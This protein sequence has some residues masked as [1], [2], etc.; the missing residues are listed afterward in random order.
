M[1][2]MGAILF[3][4]GFFLHGCHTLVCSTG[5]THLFGRRSPSQYVVA[6]PVEQV[7]GNTTHVS[8]ITN[9]MEVIISSGD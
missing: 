6:A 5:I 2:P 9:A 7:L 1:Q 4:D 8:V 3:V